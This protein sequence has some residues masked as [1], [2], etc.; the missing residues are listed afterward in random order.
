MSL[1]E[2]RARML[3]GE[4]YDDLTP[5]LIAARKAAMRR[6]DAYNASFGRHAADREALLGELVDRVGSNVHFE[7]TL[8]CEFGFNIDIGSNV[9]ANFDCILLDGGGITIGDNVLLGPRVSIYTTNHALDP[10]ERAAGACIAKQVVI[11]DDVWVGGGVTINPGVWIGRGSVIGSG[12][13]LTRSVPDGSVAAGVPAK[14]LR[15]VDAGDRIGEVWDQ[16]LKEKH[17]EEKR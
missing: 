4:W 6:S 2:Q 5:E 16:R 11:D 17:L 15:A 1:G 7:P 8:R 12:S 9:Y 10:V 13:V 14:V 3:A